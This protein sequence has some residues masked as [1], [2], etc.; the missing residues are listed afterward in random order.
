MTD[1]VSFDPNTLELR[2]VS[3]YFAEA[4]SGVTRIRW[5]LGMKRGKRIRPGTH[6]ADIVWDDEDLEDEPIRAPEGC[7]GVIRRTNRRIRTARLRRRS[8]RLLELRV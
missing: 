8:Q 4:E 6:L 2:T 3:Q 1:A 7:N 5:I